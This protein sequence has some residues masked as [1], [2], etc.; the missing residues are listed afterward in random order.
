[1]LNREEIHK[2]IQ[3]RH[4]VEGFRNLET[5]LTPN[6]FD[7]TAAQVFEFDSRGALDFS[8]KQRVLPPGKEISAHKENADDQFGWWGLAPGVYKIVTNET[9]TLPNDL[10]GIAFPR[11]SL[12]RMGAFTQTG[13]WDA[14]FAGKSEFVL[15]VQN[16]H[17]LQLKQNARVV[18]LLFTRITET[19][20]G[21]DGIYRN[22]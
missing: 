18:Q 5:Q 2:L 8:N 9:V 6:G 14:G 12:L 19:L 15:V 3:T 20:Q 22:K 21:Y 13:V 11:S 1:M 17:G 4:L 7:L 16:P 10:I